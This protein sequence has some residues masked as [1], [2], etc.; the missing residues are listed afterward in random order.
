M[1]HMFI[2]S[3]QRCT[4]SIFSFHVTGCRLKFAGAVCSFL[5]SVMCASFNA[6]PRAVSRGNTP[7]TCVHRNSHAHTQ[8]FV[9]M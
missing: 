4:I 5:S 1:E 3:P 7:P 8:Q 2:K 6:Y 9:S